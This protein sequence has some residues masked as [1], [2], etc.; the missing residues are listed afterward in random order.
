MIVLN[1]IYITFADFA[2]VFDEEMEKLRENI[3]A[4][5]GKKNI[6]MISVSTEFLEYDLLRIFGKSNIVLID[7]SN[8]FNF[9][10]NSKSGEYN[11]NYMLVNLY[12]EIPSIILRSII[13]E[14]EVNEEFQNIRDLLNTIQYISESLKEIMG[15][16]R[17]KL[18]N[19]SW[20]S[21]YV[22]QSFFWEYLN[23][24]DPPFV[25]KIIDITA[26]SKEDYE[27]FVQYVRKDFRYLGSTSTSTSTQARYIKLSTSSEYIRRVNLIRISCN[28][29]FPSILQNTDELEYSIRRSLSMYSFDMPMSDI[30]G[31]ILLNVYRY[32]LGKVH[33]EVQRIQHR[34]DKCLKMY[35]LSFVY[36][37]TLLGSIVFSKRRSEIECLLR[38]FKYNR[39]VDGSKEIAEFRYDL[40]EYMEDI[41]RDVERLESRIQNIVMRDATIVALIL[42]SIS[43][44][45]SVKSLVVSLVNLDGLSALGRFVKYIYYYPYYKFNIYYRLFKIY[46]FIYVFF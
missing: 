4:F 15:N 27:S 17:S 28:N 9:K 23:E 39:S 29:S 32:Y 40:I 44:I 14:V 36:L 2:P 20:L 35:G 33:E 45:L 10:L 31:L 6:F 42:S 22:P 30:F 7:R 12:C 3:N 21:L 8:I 11:V 37:K 25:L 34:I 41:L 38:A 18:P 43:L 24:I 26:H 13:F 1:R 19:Y 46:K 5:L 16:S